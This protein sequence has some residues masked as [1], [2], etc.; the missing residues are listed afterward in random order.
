MAEAEECCEAEI[1]LLRKQIYS[2]SLKIKELK[3]GYKNL[4]INNLQK[5]VTIRQLKQRL[6]SNKYSNFENDLPKSCI[7]KLRSI[8][9]SRKEDSVF[10]GVVLNALYSDTNTLKHK[11]LSG[12]SKN[13]E[14]TALTPEKKSILSRVYEERMSYISSSEAIVR[15]D[16]LPSILRSAIDAASRKKNITTHSSV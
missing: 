3:E 2:T 11:S 16:N 7:E 12:R 6:K 8:G 10:I 15:K 1:D 4:L 13:G 5:D 14:K 9:E